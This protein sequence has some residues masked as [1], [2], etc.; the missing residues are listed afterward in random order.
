VR[1][2][3]SGKVA[4]ISA[5]LVTGESRRLVE[6]PLEAGE[7]DGSYQS[8]FTPGAEPFRILVAGKNADGVAFQ[9]MHAPLLA[10]IR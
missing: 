8:R 7:T 9:R 10:A 3:L 5:S 1:I 4:E 6:L 2:H